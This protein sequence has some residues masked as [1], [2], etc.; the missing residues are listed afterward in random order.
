CIGIL[1]SFA[2]IGGWAPVLLVTRRAI[3]GFAVGGEGGGAA[4]LA[5]ESAPAGKKA[6]YSSGVQVG[7]GVGLLLATGL[8]SLIS[9]LTTDA[10]FLSW[11]WR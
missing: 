10:Q 1:P 3:Q 7:Y 8:V 5:V 4:L 9:Y 6:F 11:G 2:T